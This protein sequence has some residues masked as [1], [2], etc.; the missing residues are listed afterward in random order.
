VCSFFDRLGCELLVDKYSGT[1]E[2]G[3]SLNKLMKIDIL[4][5]NR[6]FKPGFIKGIW[7]M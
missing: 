5:S 3:I 2:T 6:V 7:I 4:N 1:D